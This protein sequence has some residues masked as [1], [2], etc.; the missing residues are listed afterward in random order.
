MLPTARVKRKLRYSRSK[1]LLIVKYWYQSVVLSSILLF[2]VCR[3]LMTS[4]R[5]K[6]TWD[7]RCSANSVCAA[8]NI[9]GW[10]CIL[11]L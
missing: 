7:E 4:S 3:Y 11:R 6:V 8:P 9:Y 5:K 2:S 10:R 1:I